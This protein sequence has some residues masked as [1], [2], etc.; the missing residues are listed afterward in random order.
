MSQLVAMYG[1]TNHYLTIIDA[2]I[3]VILKLIVMP[4]K[5]QES[6]ENADKIARF[7]VLNPNNVVDLHE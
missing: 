5:K 2:I 3:D 7:S 1:L 4:P 6:K